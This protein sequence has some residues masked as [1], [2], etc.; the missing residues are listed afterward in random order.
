MKWGASRGTP[1]TMIRSCFLIDSGSHSCASGWF[2]SH[3]NEVCLATKDSPFPLQNMNWPSQACCGD[4]RCLPW[5][6]FEFDCS[7][8][9]CGF[10]LYA[11]VSMIAYRQHV[12]SLLRVCLD[13]GPI[14]QF[15]QLWCRLIDVRI[16]RCFPPFHIILPFLVP[17]TTVVEED[18]VSSLD[19][20][21]N[22][23]MERQSRFWML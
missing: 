18:L 6:G 3:P 21:G 14:V 12:H 2:N 1:V 13:L 10:R 15:I 9:L 8:F 23:E 11:S 19:V 5:I 7:V 4:G 22:N 16:S 17:I 20:L